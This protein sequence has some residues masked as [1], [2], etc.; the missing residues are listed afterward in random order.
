MEEPSKDDIERRLTEYKIRGT[1][2]ELECI[3]CGDLTETTVL[4]ESDVPMTI[5]HSC[6]KDRLK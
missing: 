2:A 4:P 6:V 1:T 3:D 5:C